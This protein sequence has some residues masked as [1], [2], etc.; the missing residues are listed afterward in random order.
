M[1]G[2]VQQTIGQLFMET[3]VRSAL[4]GRSIGVRPVFVR[5]SA[6]A[7][8]LAAPRSLASRKPAVVWQML[9]IRN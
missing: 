4:A 2:E 1:G 6:F 3:D 8:A 9:A 7:R 5:P